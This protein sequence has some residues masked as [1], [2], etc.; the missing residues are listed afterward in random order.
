MG[1]EMIICQSREAWL[2]Q[3]KSY[4]G[5]S[6]AACVVGM[7][8]WKTNVDLWME[9]TGRKAAPDIS[10]KAA[11]HY[12]AEA[13]KY[14]RGLYALDNENR[15]QVDYAENNMWL[16][17]YFDFAHASLDGWITEKDTGRKG[18]LEIKT[19]NIVQSMQ[20]E[21]WKDRVPDNYY[22]QILHYMMITGFSFAELHCQLRYDYG[23]DIVFQ[24][25]TY[26]IERAEVE[27]DISYLADKERDFA[28]YIKQDKRPALILPEI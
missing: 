4:I 16:N 1:A 23:G 21:K 27:D 8:P 12:G 20:R 13:E 14:L 26:H 15:F 9:K 6:D 2:A 28:E 3:R 19:T 5:G 22:L 24:R 25:R 7:N 11:V 18:I 10:D 17:P